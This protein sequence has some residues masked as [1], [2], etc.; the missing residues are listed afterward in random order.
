MRWYEH[1]LLWQDIPPDRSR[2]RSFHKVAV[3]EKYEDHE[4]GEDP[5]ESMPQAVKT[6]WN[7]DWFS[8]VF[9]L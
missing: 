8:N 2:K 7:L 9:Y 6:W 3:Y 5:E 4:E 1:L